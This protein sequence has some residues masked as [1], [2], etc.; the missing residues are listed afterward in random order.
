MRRRQ[1]IEVAMREIRTRGRSRGYRVITGIM[2][3][4][5]IIA[6]IVMVL[7]PSPNDDL[8]DVT[9]GVSAG[10]PAGFEEQLTIIAGNVV[11]LTIVDL[12]DTPVDDIGT[13]LSDGRLDVALRP[14]RTLMWDETEDS[15]M[16]NVVTAALQQAEILARADELGFEVGDLTQVFAPVEL[17]EV[18]VN[19]STNTEGV[20]T[21]VAMF[22]LFLAFLLPQVFGQF[23][24]MSVVEEKSTR[25]VEVLLSQI[26]PGTL[27]AGK[28]F[29][30][31]ALAMLQLAVIVSGLVAALLTTNVV[32]VPASVWQFVPLMTISILG[33][34]AIYTTLFALL[35]SLISRQEDQAQ[36]MFPVFA[37][38]MIGYFVGQT[39]VFGNAETLF[40]KILTWF[41]LTTPMLLPVRVAR[42]TIGPIETA[43]SL[44]LLAL[45]AYL[46]FRLASRV[47]EFTLL[48]T[49][50]RVGWGELIRLSRGNVL[51]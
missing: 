22:G 9:I 20:R 45:G 24:M 29:G 7:L 14:P 5:S 49:G 19:G 41:P 1:V 37:P 34:L 44:S 10:T 15:T 50:S 11:D 39:A 23:T 28:I 40:V 30:L 2:L 43:I 47:Y 8:R 16:A 46:L 3:L 26:R 12:G 31:C 25:V 51:D 18:F 13:Q 42:G 36:V 38:L 17:D 4:L 6:P 35:G 32:D 33:G 27:L 48:R 21:G